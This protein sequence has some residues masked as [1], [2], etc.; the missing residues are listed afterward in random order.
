MSTSVKAWDWEGQ[1]REHWAFVYSHHPLNW[2]SRRMENSSPNRENN[3]T[4]V[5]VS[6]CACMC[7]Y[8]YPCV[9]PCMPLCVYVCVPVYMCLCVLLCV[10]VYVVYVSVSICTCVCAFVCVFRGCVCVNCSKNWFYSFW[11]IDYTSLEIT[12]V[13]KE[14]SYKDYLIENEPFLPWASPRWCTV[15]LDVHHSDFILTIVT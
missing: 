2:L 7:V 14:V 8:A 5:C 10:T 13:W 4:F 12:L 15:G 11:I 6:L 3:F 9:C 1:R